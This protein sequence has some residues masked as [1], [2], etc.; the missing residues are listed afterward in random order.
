MFGYFKR[1]A[2]GVETVEE[3]AVEEVKKLEQEISPPA[4]PVEPPAA[5]VEPQPPV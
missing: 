4:A 2:Q 5:P 1:V 3:A